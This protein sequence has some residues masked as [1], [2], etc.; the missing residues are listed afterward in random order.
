[1]HNIMN[2]EHPNMSVL[3]QLDF[4]NLDKN[5]DI[6]TKDFIW[7][8]Q[9][10]EL[11]DLEGDYTGLEGLK[12]FFNQLAHRTKGSFKVK[13]LSIFPLGDEIVVT[14]VKDTMVLAGKP[15]EIDAVVLWCI[16]DGK[17]KEAWDI[18]VKHTAR[19]LVSS[20]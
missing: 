11:P 14:H 6:I 5:A 10:P 7:H 16:I 4:G 1:M 9:N 18:P 3:Q 19:M 12:D 17:I 13:P 8:Y 2:K 20:Y 15:M